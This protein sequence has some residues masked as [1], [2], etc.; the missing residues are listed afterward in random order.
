LSSNLVT[1]PNLV[2]A[3]VDCIYACH[4]FILIGNSHNCSILGGSPVCNIIIGNRVVGWTVDAD[5]LREHS[6]TIRNSWKDPKLSEESKTSFLRI[7]TLR[8]LTKAPLTVLMSVS[9]DWRN[10]RLHD[11][12]CVMYFREL[13]LIHRPL[14]QTT[15]RMT[16]LD[17]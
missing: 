2:I 17:Q 8:E 12:Y 7:G 10:V 4:T 5:S 11:L 3:C 16:S 1:I 6:E 13:S 9:Q 15:P 14:G